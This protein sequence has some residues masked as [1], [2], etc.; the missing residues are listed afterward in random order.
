MDTHWKTLTN[1]T[2]LGSYAFENNRDLIGTI[3]VVKSEIVTGD[4]GRKEECAV[5]YFAEDIKPMILNKTNMK[6]I[7]KLVG[8]PYIEKW[9][10]KKIQ[11]YV[12][13]KV[14]YGKEITGGLRIREKL[15]VSNELCKCSKCG[16]NIEPTSN[17][18][19]KQISDYTVARFG[20]A[21]CSECAHSKNQEVKNNAVDE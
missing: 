1:P 17:M 7:T 10:G 20:Q 11:I 5:C 2:Y 14:K 8:T 9:V 6:T 19:S 16:K 18:T 3:K 13:P 12:D 15:M 4:G 21:L